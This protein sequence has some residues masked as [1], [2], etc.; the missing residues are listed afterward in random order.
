MG[1]TERAE[2]AFTAWL[3]ADRDDM[4]DCH[5]CELNG[6]GWWHAVRGRDEEALGVWEQALETA[7]AA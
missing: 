1:D 6:Q 2:L 4:A 3:D 7:L 5:A